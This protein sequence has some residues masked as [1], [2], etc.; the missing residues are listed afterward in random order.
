M[1][2]YECGGE[3]HDIDGDLEIGDRYV[4]SFLVRAVHYRKCDSCGQVLFPLG[5]AEAIERRRG[6]RKDELLKGRPLRAFL[7]AAE[8]ATSLGISRQA[9]HKHRRIR[10]GFIHQ[11]AFGSGVVYLE[12]SVKLF[13]ATGDGRFPLC[14]SPGSVGVEKLP[15]LDELP[16]R[17]RV[18]HAAAARRKATV[19][20]EGK[21]IKHDDFWRETEAEYK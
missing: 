10:R 2:C 7:T 14:P 5:T 6:E 17:T 1:K 16:D 19:V 8:T 13:K 18:V 4:G 11:T 15:M 9:L 3:Y 20:R 12:E 21:G